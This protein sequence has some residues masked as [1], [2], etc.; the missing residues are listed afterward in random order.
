M[1]ALHDPA[2]A[3][4]LQSAQDAAAAIDWL[5]GL[6]GAPLPAA[7]L[8][9]LRGREGALLFDALGALAGCPEGAAAMRAACLRGDSAA[10]AERT[11]S[12]AFVRLFEGVSGPATVSLYESVHA[13]PARR[14][15]QR[16]A[17]EM[18]QVLATLSVAVGGAGRE[19]A[20]HLAIELALLALAL[21]R[22]AHGI[23]Q[24]LRE[25][26][27]RWVPGVAAQLAGRDDADN[28]N[29]E[30]PRTRHRLAQFGEPVIGRKAAAARV[31]GQRRMRND[32]QKQCDAEKEQHTIADVETGQSELHLGS[33]YRLRVI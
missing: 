6:F 27:L 19:S 21:Q 25:R 5:A 4:A 11:L 18:G 2:A 14:L 15:C 32:Q 26:L 12:Q 16:Q 29:G 23:A 31:R 13:D 7:A 28:R 8:E 3:P 10:Q 33:P 22:G 9:R 17:G 30:G 1:D 20:D 24:G